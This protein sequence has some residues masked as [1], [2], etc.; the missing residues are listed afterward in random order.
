MKRITIVRW[1][2]FGVV[3]VVVAVVAVGA[4]GALGT[5]G[6]GPRTTGGACDQVAD[7]CPDQ[8]DFSCAGDTTQTCEENADGCLVWTDGV[9]CGAGTVCAAGGCCGDGEITGGELCDGANLDGATCQS[10]GYGTGILACLGTCVGYDIAGCS[11]TG[12]CGNGVIEG[13]EPCDGDN[14]GVASC[15]TEDFYDGTITCNADCT[16]NTSGC[17][18]YCGDGTLNGAE[19][20]DNGAMGTQTCDDFGY[21]F[22][23][24]TCDSNCAYDSAT[25]F[26]RCGDGTINGTEQCDGTQL[27]GATCFDYGF[28]SGGLSCDANCDIDSSTCVGSCGDGVQN[29]FEACDGSDFATATCVGFGF[30]AGSLTCD[31]GCV[32]DTSSCEVCIPGQYH[33]FGNELQECAAGP[34]ADWSTIQTCN[35][36]AGYACDA[37]NGVCRD[38]TPIGGTTPTGT[39]YQY[40]LFTTGNSVFMGGCDVGSDGDLVYVNRGAWYQDGSTMDVYRITLLDTDGDGLLE[41]NQHPNNPLAPGPIEERV[42]THVITYN[43][44]ELGMVHRSEIFPMTDRAFFVSGNIYPGT[45]F[46]YIFGTGVTNI[47]ADPVINL[48][49]G[50][51][52]YGS[53]DGRWYAAYESSRRVYSYHDATSEWVAE[54]EFPNLAGNHMDAIEVV[55]SP[56]T[57]IQY[58]YV[59][60]MTSDYLGQYR[61]NFMTGQWVQENLF[62][63]AGTGSL[64]EGM[65]FGALN[66]F[67]VTGNGSDLYEIGG[68]D[69]SSYIDP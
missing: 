18:G 57:G 49:V 60:D 20:C 3:M 28:Y 37:V 38:L 69:L 41:P 21:Y 53:T 62:E 35:A 26:E 29:G 14:L 46:E 40:A 15:A 2:L 33:C 67:W 6:C 47:V 11:G 24:L 59:S 25:C 16:V 7:G 61:K 23:S 4:L 9:T 36:A 42:L 58:V 52:G 31:A 64:V 34:P 8:G 22:G 55:T 19:D 51:L 39:Y 54:F 50:F 30:A 32:I 1:P 68:G 12:T 10:A 5:L 17:S 66:H 48:D 44:P 13:A 27:A 56:G 45:V 43:V 65:G 63:Y